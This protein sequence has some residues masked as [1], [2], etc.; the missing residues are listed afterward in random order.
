MP[1]S[2]PAR[3]QRGAMC[4]TAVELCVP[5]QL[6]TLHPPYAVTLSIDVWRTRIPLYVELQVLNSSFVSGIFYLCSSLCLSLPTCKDTE[7][8]TLSFN[9][10][11]SSPLTPV[12]S[13]TKIYLE[14]MCCFSSPPSSSFSHQFLSCLDYCNTLLPGMPILT[15]ATIWCLIHISARETI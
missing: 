4:P 2:L 3:H 15:L 13:T 1:R 8:K 14:C 6:S 12:Y 10:L 11:L 5:T 7:V 9:Q